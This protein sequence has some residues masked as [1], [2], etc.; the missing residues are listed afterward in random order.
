MQ[1]TRTV[2][3]VLHARGYGAEIH[4]RAQNDAVGMHHLVVEHV[5]IVMD[6]AAI[7]TQAF[8][9]TAAEADIKMRQLDELAR[10]TLMTGSLQNGAQK[11]CSAFAGTMATVDGQNVHSRLLIAYVTP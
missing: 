5:H 1:R 7:G 6:G 8:V 3:E 10:S 9:A 2:H 11:R 4:R